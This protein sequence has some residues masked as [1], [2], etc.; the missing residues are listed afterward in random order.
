[1]SAIQCPNCGSYATVRE[2]G[3]FDWLWWVIGAATF[4]LRVFASFAR[5]GEM[6]DQAPGRYICR[7]CGQSFTYFV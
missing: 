4:F 2:A 5:R 6:A 1:M 7:G 3:P